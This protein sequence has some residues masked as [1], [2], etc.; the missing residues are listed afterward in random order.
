MAG[1]ISSLLVALELSIFICVFLASTFA[2][3]M[4]ARAWR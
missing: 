1:L 4:P 2:D 3:F